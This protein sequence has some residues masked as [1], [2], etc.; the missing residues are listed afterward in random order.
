M[1]KPNRTLL[2]DNSISRRQEVGRGLRICVDQQGNRQDD[3]ATV[4]QTN[5]LTVV[6]SESYKAFVT[7]LQSEISES[8]SERPRTAN[9]DYFTGKVLVVSGEKIEVSS[10]MAKQIYRY[11]VKNDYTDDDDRIT[12][13]YHEAVKNDALSVLPKALQPYRDQVFELIGSIKAGSGEYI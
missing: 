7:S 4:H 12:D 1:Q 10:Q 9:V 5:V 3:P 11:L 6:A 13:E 8:L 2:S